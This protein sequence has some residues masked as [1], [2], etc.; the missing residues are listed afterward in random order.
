MALVHGVTAQTDLISSVLRVLLA[1]EHIQ[2]VGPGVQDR[3]VCVRACVRG[4]HL[5]VLFKASLMRA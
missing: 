4:T 1:L 5:P 3:R 2:V